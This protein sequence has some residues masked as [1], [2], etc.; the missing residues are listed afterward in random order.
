MKNRTIFAIVVVLAVVAS[1]CKNIA[2]SGTTSG[3]EGSGTMLSLNEGYDNTRNGARLILN[4]DAQSNSFNGTVENTTANTLKRVRV[5]VHLSNGVE[6]GPTTPTDLAAGESLDISLAASSN[7][8]DGWTPHAEVGAGESGGEG[9][10][11]TAGEHGSG[12]EGGNEGGGSELGEAA[13]SSPITPLG[14]SWDGVLGDLAISMRYDATTKS[15]FGTVENIS[16]QTLCYVQVEPHLKS[17]TQTVG[18]LGPEKL[19]DLNSGQQVNSSLSVDSEPNLA[20]VAF[21]GYVI[22]MEVFDCNG[23]G[24]IPHAGGEGSEGAGGE[25]GEGGHSEGSGG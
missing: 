14:Q 16:T 13:M 17:G 19:G 4:Y 22:H 7:G 1:A 24:P 11:E 15:V 20:S 25:S 10:S 6:L 8:F 23:P 12:G 18:E 2:E 3:E 9:G 5:E 21:D